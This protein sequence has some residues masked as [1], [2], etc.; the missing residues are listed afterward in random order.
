M[1]LE[2]TLYLEISKG[3]VNWWSLVMRTY[4][5]DATRLL[6]E[7]LLLQRSQSEQQRRRP[8]D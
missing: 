2:G 6:F 4:R 7:P 5:V 3:G 1:S 8:P